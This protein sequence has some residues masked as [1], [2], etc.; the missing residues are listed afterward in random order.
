M[1]YNLR[2]SKKDLKLQKQAQSV[3]RVSSTDR[4]GLHGPIFIDKL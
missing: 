1:I 2:L 4:I 3:W